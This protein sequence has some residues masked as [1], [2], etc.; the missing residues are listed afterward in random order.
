MLYVQ[1]LDAHKKDISI[2]KENETSEKSMWLHE[3]NQH[4]Q[5][6]FVC[7]YLEGTKEYKTW[8]L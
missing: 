7:L 2:Q 6:V 5:H 8:D 1:L 4:N 3:G